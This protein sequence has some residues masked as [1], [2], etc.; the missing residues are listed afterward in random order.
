MVD[1]ECVCSRTQRSFLYRFYNHLAEVMLKKPRKITI[2]NEFSENCNI[3]NLI[4]KLYSTF[5]YYLGHDSEYI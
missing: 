1:N 5:G 3:T 2:K 4:Q